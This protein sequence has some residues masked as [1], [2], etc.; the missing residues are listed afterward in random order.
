[1]RFWCPKGVRRPWITCEQLRTAL[2]RF[3][4]D[5]GPAIEPAT[6]FVYQNDRA[7]ADLDGLQS[8]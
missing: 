7:S 8:A 3:R 6:Q 1:M 5:W 4:D 2:G